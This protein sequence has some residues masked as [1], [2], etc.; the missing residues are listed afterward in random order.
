MFLRSHLVLTSLLLFSL[1]LVA[2]EPSQRISGPFSQS[3]LTVFLLHGKD[4]LSGDSKLMTLDEALEKKKLIVHETSNVNLLAVENISDDVEVFVQ[5]GDIVKGGRQDRL[6]ACDMI[7]PHKSGKVP[8]S[9]FCCENG[10]WKQR[11]S[12]SAAE[13][14]VSNAQAANQALKLAVNSSR[15]QAE[16]WARVREAQKKLAMNVGKPVANATSPSSYQLT[17]E[18]KEVLT[19]VDNYTT[20]LKKLVED[21]ADA[22]GFVIVINGKVEGAELYGSHSLFLKLWPKLIFG[23]AV[24][25][26][27]ELDAK[28]T[29]KLP[30]EKDIEVF[31]VDASKG[32]EKEIVASAATNQQMLAPTSGAQ[33]RPNSNIAGTGTSKTDAGKPSRVVVVSTEN[34]KTVLLEAR[35]R[36]DNSIVH[37]SYIAK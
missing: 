9:S 8:I 16:V 24:D 11:G 27:S 31:L 18:D 13:F 35:D 20:D 3:N 33:P 4:T 32:K 5:S 19:K 29:F 7:V 37:R 30:T 21:N 17:L 10:R 26:L 34:D 25:A 15:D 12:E 2:T 28:K 1:P 22:I 14:G 23:A 36:K 6:I